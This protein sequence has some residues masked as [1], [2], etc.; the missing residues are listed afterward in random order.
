MHAGSQART[1]IQ[2]ELICLGPEATAYYCGSGYFLEH[3]GTQKLTIFGSGVGK[4]FAKQFRSYMAKMALPLIG[5]QNSRLPL[6][7][8]PN[9]I[10]SEKLLRFFCYWHFSD[11]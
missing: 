8:R 2:G 10:V 1:T 3:I 4:L 6:I 7:G 11:R 5:R 9:G